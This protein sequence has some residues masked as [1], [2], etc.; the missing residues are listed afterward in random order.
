MALKFPLILG[1]TIFAFIALAESWQNGALQMHNKLRKCHGVPSLT[2]SH[3]VKISLVF[4]F[5][6]FYKLSINFYYS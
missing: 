5:I 3:T 4:D 2:L 6:K 1:L